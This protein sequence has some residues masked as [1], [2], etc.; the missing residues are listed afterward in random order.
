MRFLLATVG[1]CEYDTF[2]LVLSYLKCAVAETVL[3]WFGTS[4][5][6]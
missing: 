5:E 4:A 6:I 1:V 2:G 3:W